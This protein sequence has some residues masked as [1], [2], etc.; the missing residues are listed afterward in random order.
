MGALARWTFQVWDK[1]WSGRGGN[2]PETITRYSVVRHLI[3]HDLHHRGEI[4]ITLGGSA[5][6]ELQL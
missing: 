1:I 3:E 5:I 4:S 2:E 6:R